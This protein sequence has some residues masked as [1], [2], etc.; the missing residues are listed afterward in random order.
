MRLFD[1]FRRRVV[2]ALLVVLIL[3]GYGSL[4]G[5]RYDDGHGGHHDDHWDHR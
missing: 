5:C 2:R 1:V 4:T 3:V